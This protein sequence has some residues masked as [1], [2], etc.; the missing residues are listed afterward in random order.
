MNAVIDRENGIIYILFTHD[1]FKW[2]S[3]KVLIAQNIAIYKS[4][5][6]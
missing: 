5:L 4:H 2:I 3:N 1:S 6:S